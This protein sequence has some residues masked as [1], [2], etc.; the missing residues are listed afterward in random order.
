MAAQVLLPRRRLGKTGLMVSTPALGGVGLGN[1]YGNNTEDAAVAAVVQAVKRGINF[2]D[3]SPLY[4]ESERVLG[5]AFKKIF[6]EG[7]ARRED[8]VI[9]S[10]V[11]DECPPF[12]DNGG[13]HAM[14]KEGV[15]SSVRHSLKQ[16]GLE[17]LDLVL[18]HDP[19]VEDV[20]T[21]LE[22]KG[23]L[24]GLKE[25]RS[26]GKIGYFGIGCVEHVQ[27]KLFIDSGECS[28]VL[29]VN[30]YNLIRRYAAEGNVLNEGT[31]EE[32][33][34]EA[35]FAICKEQDIGIMNAGALYCGLLADPEGGWDQGFKKD[36]LLKGYPKSVDL[37]QR[38]N[39]WVQ[40]NS[41]K[42][43]GG[44][45]VHIRTVAL[46]FALR[47]EAVTTAPIGCRSVAEVDGM[48]DAVQ[49]PLSDD[50]WTALDGEFGEEI[51]GMSWGGDH[52][53]YDKAS[54]KI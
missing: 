51:K 41:A 22:A 8:L 34:G 2:I 31:P 49:E 15:M 13:H 1:I 30:D 3:T 48:C 53:R 16:M 27:Q 11:G 32:T 45:P 23:G 24:E 9:C 10:K 46:Q 4:G 5:V 28:V 20:K 38:I 26:Q 37:V 40:E 50:F 17:K 6:G 14:S 44:K 12:S 42:Y 47:H 36:V 21:F 52:W 43:T 39:K 19:T 33:R 54:S 29:T 35:P 25:L 7:I 18:L